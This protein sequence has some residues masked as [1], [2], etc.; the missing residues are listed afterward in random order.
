MVDGIIRIEEL[1]DYA[2]THNFPSIALTDNT[3]LFGL[4]KFYRLAREKG[5]K[6]IVG[7]E[8]K[9]V[10]NENKS[11]APIVLLVKNKKG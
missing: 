8:I 10:G 7:S 6:P 3:N 4:I 11:V 9:I 1:V 5:I 2:A